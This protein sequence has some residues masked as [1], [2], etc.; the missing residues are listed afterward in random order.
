MNSRRQF[1]STVACASL[2]TASLSTFAQSDWPTKPVKLIVPFTAGGVTD[3]VTRI[4]AEGMRKHMPGANFVVDNRPGV[5]GNLGAS[6]VANGPPDGYTLV[7][8]T[9]STYALNA[10]LYS[11]LGHDP[12]KD[13]VAVGMMATA[14]FCIVVHPALGVRDLKSFIALL[15]A[16]PGKYNFG[17]AGNGTSG[18]VAL[19]LLLQKIGA[20]AQHI[21]YR[22]TSQLMTDLLANN[23]QFVVASPSVIQDHLKDGKLVALAAVSPTRMSVLPQVPTVAEAGLKDYDVYSWNC[24]FAP[25]K[26]PA[27]VVQRLH[28]AVAATL[29][30]PSVRS[31]LEQQ[32]TFPIDGLSLADTDRYV[33]KEYERWVPFVKQ[34]GLKAE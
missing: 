30:D 7:A 17:S 10:G 34:M 16:N 19:H 32:G 20:Q 31:R 2:S 27:A 4:V 33:R 5:G 24:L 13:L 6:L 14:P 26:T 28:A 23:V 3:L 22:G 29:K 15:K 8:G 25:A 12:R 9:L 1:L 18:H 11:N 21:P